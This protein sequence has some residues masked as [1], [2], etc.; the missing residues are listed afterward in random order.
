[1]SWILN[2]LFN[3]F[4]GWKRIIGIGINWIVAGMVA[5]CAGSPYC[6]DVPTAE[7]TTVLFWIAQI[8]LAWGSAAAIGK[9]MRGKD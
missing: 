7:F 2:K 4:D 5:F 6:S 8:F 9:K 3:A 1:M